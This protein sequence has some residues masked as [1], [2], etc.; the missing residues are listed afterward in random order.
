MSKECPKKMAAA[1]HKSK[2]LHDQISGQMLNF[3]A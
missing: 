3:L 2:M 1:L